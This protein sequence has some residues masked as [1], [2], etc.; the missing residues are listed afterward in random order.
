MLEG[1]D[2]DA[3]GIEIDAFRAEQAARLGIKV[4]EASA[5]QVHA[6]A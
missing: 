5:F 4:L 6:F 2:A 3:H 1:S